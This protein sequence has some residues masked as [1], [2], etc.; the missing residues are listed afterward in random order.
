MAKTITI[1]NW[2]A[3]YPVGT[4]YKGQCAQYAGDLYQ[5]VYGFPYVQGNG[6]EK[7]KKYI[8]KYKGKGIIDATNSVK[9]TGILKA[10][11]MVSIKTKSRVGHV[12]IVLSDCTLD[13]PHGIDSNWSPTTDCIIR[14][15]KTKS[16]AGSR[17]TNTILGVARLETAADGY[18]G[19]YNLEAITIDYIEWKGKGSIKKDN[20]NLLW[21]KE[22]NKPIKKWGFNGGEFFGMKDETFNFLGRTTDKKYYYGRCVGLCNSTIKCVVPCDKINKGT[23]KSTGKKKTFSFG[24]TYSNSNRNKSGKKIIIPKYDDENM[25]PEHKVKQ[26]TI[27]SYEFSL[28]TYERG[29]YSSGGRRIN[30]AY[31]LKAIQKE[32]L[33]KKEITLG[34][35]SIDGKVI[36]ACTT[37]FGTDGDWITWEFDDGRTLDTIIGDAKRTRNRNE[38]SNKYGHYYGAGVLEFVGVTN[39]A[40]GNGN[41]FKTIKI[42]GKILSGSRVVAGYNHGKYIKW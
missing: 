7:A 25:Y 36:I 17:V 26:G 11:D 31:G 27:G 41:P 30:F 24:T 5:A 8:N 23:G 3:K 9:K 10:G 40:K 32:W 22:D 14:E 28:S 42:N 29:W 38:H 6:G 39:S 4:K 18:E 19:N 13:S 12:W 34:C 37:T 33:K 16:S 20:T 21:Y 35:A 1:E 2:I 15:F